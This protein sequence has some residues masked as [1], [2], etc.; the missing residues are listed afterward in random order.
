ML[1]QVGASLEISTTNGEQTITVQCSDLQAV[2]LQITSRPFPGFST[3]WGPMV[4][5]LLTQVPG[6]H[7]FHE[8][9]FAQRFAHV[10]ELVRMGAQIQGVTVPVDE[11]LSNFDS[12]FL[13]PAAHSIQICGP[14]TLSGTVMRANDVRAGAA[15]ALA[16]LRAEGQTAITGIEQIERGYEC[17]AERLQQLGAS[18]A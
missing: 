10:P 14:N 1:Q 11:S 3:D 17:F 15:L 6:Q 2:D 8:T 5:T 13:A 16:G 9:I 12:A 18:I 4:Q 7:L